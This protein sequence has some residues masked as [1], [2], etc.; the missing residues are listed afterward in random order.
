MNDIQLRLDASEQYGRRD[1]LEIQ[2]IPDIA[3]D[4]RIQLVIGTARL[5]DVELEP[6]DTSIAHRLPSRNS[7]RQRKIIVKFTRLV[8]EDEVFNTR[9][10]LKSK[11]TKDLPSVQIQ[12]ESSSVSHNAAIHINESLTPY[13]K[14]LF[15][16]SL[17][18]KKNHH[19]KYLWTRKGKIMLRESDSSTSHSFVSFEEFD[20]YLDSF[21]Q[22]R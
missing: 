20:E 19:F 21:S 10:K 7:Q 17:D 14:R 12:S 15:G 16:R 2:G 1:T 13:R 6:N 4:I 8:K 22:N 11:R 9:K 5:V 18:F 3:Y